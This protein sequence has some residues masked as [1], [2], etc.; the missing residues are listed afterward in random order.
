MPTYAGYGVSKFRPLLTGLIQQKWLKVAEDSNGFLFVQL[1]RADNFYQLP[2]VPRQIKLVPRG[3]V[4]VVDVFSDEAHQNRVFQNLTVVTARGSRASQQ[5]Q[6]NVPTF[7]LGF[8]SVNLATAMR[9]AAGHQGFQSAVFAPSA[10]E[11]FAFGRPLQHA[12]AS[13]AC[14]DD[15]EADD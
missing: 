14:D 4:A 11:F 5:L 9:L 8:F 2:V 3:V 1:L 12:V 6:V 15:T 10:L 7:M 13:S